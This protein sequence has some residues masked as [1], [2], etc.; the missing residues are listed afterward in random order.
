MVNAPCSSGVK[1][2]FNS[3]VE[4][5]SVKLIPV[6]LNTSHKSGVFISR[7]SIEVHSTK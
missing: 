4:G 7:F 5:S 1:P 6:V 2:E 3:V